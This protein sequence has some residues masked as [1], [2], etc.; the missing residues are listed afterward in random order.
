MNTQPTTGTHKLFS[1]VGTPQVKRTLVVLSAAVLVLVIAYV[2]GGQPA[3]PLTLDTDGACC[4]GP[5]EPVEFHV[6]WGEHLAHQPTD[7]SGHVWVAGDWDETTNQYPCR[8]VPG[9]YD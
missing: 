4:Y 1:I 8:V 2:A 7:G 3:P 6:T 5:T 9:N